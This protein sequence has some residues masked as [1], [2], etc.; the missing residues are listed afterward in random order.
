MSSALIPVFNNHLPGKSDVD[1]VVEGIVRLQN[2]YNVS[3]SALAGGSTFGYK[4]PILSG[5]LTRQRRIKT[6]YKFNQL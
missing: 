1:G 5:K 6:N 4:V 3:A 2:T